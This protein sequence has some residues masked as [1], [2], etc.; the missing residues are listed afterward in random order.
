MRL[1]QLNCNLYLHNHQEIDIYFMEY[2]QIFKITIVNH[3]ID[4][5][6][7]HIQ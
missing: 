3:N 4:H 5:V 1:L 2:S 6:Y 7:R